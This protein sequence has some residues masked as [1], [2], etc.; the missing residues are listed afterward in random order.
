MDLLER[1]RG[2]NGAKLRRLQAIGLL[3]GYIERRRDE[4]SIDEIRGLLVDAAEAML[5]TAA[6]IETDAG[7]MHWIRSA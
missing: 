1:E 3:L 2:V 5:D 7:E 6:N 4:L